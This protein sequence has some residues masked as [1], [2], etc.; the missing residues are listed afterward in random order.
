M[1]KI[2]SELRIKNILVVH[3]VGDTTKLKFIS[4]IGPC[5]IT[6]I[7]IYMYLNQGC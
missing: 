5:S 6:V 3:L 4:V 2:M 7:C 1:I